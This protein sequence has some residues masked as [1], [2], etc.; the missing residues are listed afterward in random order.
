[1]IRG[2]PLRFHNAMSTAR[3]WIYDRIIIRK[4]ERTDK[5]QFFKNNLVKIA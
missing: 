5:I 4:I 1:M 3:I 2:Y